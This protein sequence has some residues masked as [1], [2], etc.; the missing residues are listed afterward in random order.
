MQFFISHS[1]CCFRSFLFLLPLANFQQSCSSLHWDTAPTFHSLRSNFR[2]ADAQ[3]CCNW[4]YS[5]CKSHNPYWCFICDAILWKETCFYFPVVLGSRNET[6]EL[7]DWSALVH[8]AFTCARDDRGT[9]WSS[10][11]AGVRG[12]TTEMIQN[13][14]S[15]ILHSGT[16]LDDNIHITQH[17]TI[18]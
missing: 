16:V 12:L 14:S 8:G 17:L 5:T 10:L 1:A 4:T 13:S 6:A 7:R 11:L 15:K 9:R 18:F 3:L 2:S